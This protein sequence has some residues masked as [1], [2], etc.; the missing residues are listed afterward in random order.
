M[1][2]KNMLDDWLNEPIS[3]EAAY[4]LYRF[5]DRLVFEIEAHYLFQIRR[6]LQNQETSQNSPEPHTFYFDDDI[7]F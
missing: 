5:L 6:H 2:N 3:D 7:D 1:N 4:T